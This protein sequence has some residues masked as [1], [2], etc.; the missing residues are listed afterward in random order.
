MGQF[1]QEMLE[2]EKRPTDRRPFGDPLEDPLEEMLTGVE[3]SGAKSV[4]SCLRTGQ[5]RELERKIRRLRF[6]LNDLDFFEVD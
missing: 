6:Y 4:K 1:G 5:G 3:E 2:G